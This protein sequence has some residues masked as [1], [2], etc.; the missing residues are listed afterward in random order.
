MEELYKAL[1]VVAA[2][3]MGFAGF[4]FIVVKFA[5]PIKNFFTKV[6]KTDNIDK[7]YNDIKVLGGENKAQNEEIKNINMQLTSL[8]GRF[9]KMEMVINDMADGVIV[10]LDNK[11]NSS[12]NDEEQRR[13]LANLKRHSKV[14]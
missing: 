5:E 4:I 6:K 2:A 10:L 8:N 7:N 3:F 1:I 11:I 9:G 13:A 12:N 14:V